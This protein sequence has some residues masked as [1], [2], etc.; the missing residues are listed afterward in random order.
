MTG[1]RNPILGRL[2]GQLWKPLAARR[3]AKAGMFSAESAMGA[4][5]C[6]G[7]RQRVR[8]GETCYIVG[9][10]ISGHN[11]GASLVQVSQSGGVQLLSNDEE[12]RFTAV[13]HYQDYPEQSIDELHRRL[14]SLGV[15]PTQIVA[16]AASWDY[17]M[18][19]ATLA[20]AFTENLPAS[21]TLLRPGATN[22]WDAVAR[23]R[24]ALSAPARLRQQLGLDAATPLLM[25]EHHENH[26]SFA[27][28]A[29]PFAKSAGSTMITV[30]DGSGD[31]GGISL[32]HGENGQISQVYYN[33][34]MSNSLG[35]FYAYLS[36]T[37]GGAGLC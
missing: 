12:E 33:E 9:L 26:A 27:Y 19:E 7:I 34:S 25:P 22:Y 20:R 6:D 21:T 16:W 8:S 17:G 1:P 32:Y 30:L 18:L 23:S 13:K 15:R 31:R 37:Q 36:S 28:A 14:Q 3:Y 2:V 35:L 24:E 4:K 10:G 11:A 5:V 29:S